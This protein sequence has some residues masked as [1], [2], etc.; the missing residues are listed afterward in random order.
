[1]TAGF[2]HIGAWATSTAYLLDD[3]VT[4][5][6]QTYRTLSSHS[7]GVFATDLAASKWAKFSGGM[8]WKGNWATS[9]VYKVNDIVNSGGA[10]YVATA[11]HT[12]SSF[13][14]D[15]AHWDSFANAGTDVATIITTHGDFLVR[16]ATGPARL[17][18]GANGQILQ[19]GGANANP[20][21]LAQGTDGQ[22]LQSG[23]AAADPKYL[24]QGTSGQLLT[25]AGAAADPTWETPAVAAGFTIAGYLMYS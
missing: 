18:P 13:G 3:I 22:I 23:G 10:V 19:S 7:S 17:G 5:G 2:R 16:D 6:G 11:D 25:S 20:K 8:D 9:T 4:Y 1:M 12:A 15:S 14:A 24:A 21:F